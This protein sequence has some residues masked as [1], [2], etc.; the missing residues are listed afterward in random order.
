MGFN[1]EGSSFPSPSMMSEWWA[2][3][4][5]WNFHRMTQTLE[6]PY[7]PHTCCSTGFLWWSKSMLLGL[8]WHMR[9]PIDLAY[10]IFCK[11]SKVEPIICLRKLLL[12]QNM[13]FQI[14]HRFSRKFRFIS[15][16]KNSWWRWWYL[17]KNFSTEIT[18]AKFI[19]HLLNSQFQKLG[20]IFY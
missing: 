9:H 10:W 1:R 3:S 18:M 2:I 14:L 4:L 8:L 20:F 19:E 12:M 17:Q 16:C 13:L 5:P 7:M 6:F 11:F 15:P